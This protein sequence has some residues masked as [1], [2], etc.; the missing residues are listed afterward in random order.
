MFTGGFTVLTGLAGAG[1]AL[2]VE[3][4]IIDYVENTLHYKK[5]KQELNTLNNQSNN[6]AKID[7]VQNQNN[8]FSELSI[9]SPIS[10]AEEKL[11]DE[12]DRLQKIG[13]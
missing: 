12:I 6:S 10:K 2:V 8:N 1:W 13:I 4:N 3:S 7:I 9:N 5:I 11:K